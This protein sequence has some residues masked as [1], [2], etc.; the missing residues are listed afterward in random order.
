VASGQ[1]GRSLA[2]TTNIAIM[3]RILHG[4]EVQDLIHPNTPSENLADIQERDRH[5]AVLA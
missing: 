1:T 5:E 3:N 4:I 2:T